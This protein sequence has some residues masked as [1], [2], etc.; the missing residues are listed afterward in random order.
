[1]RGA[2]IPADH[3]LRKK[4][5]LALSGPASRRSQNPSFSV[6]FPLRRSDAICKFSETL[7]GPQF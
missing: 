1:M 2:W 5:A 6:L 3:M 4:S 7:D